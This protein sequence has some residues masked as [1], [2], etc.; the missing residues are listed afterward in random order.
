MKLKIN[1]YRKMLLYF[2][3]TTL[4][5][6]IASLGYISYKIKQISSKTSRNLL[7]TH[8]EKVG[9][10]VRGVL[11][12]NIYAVNALANAYQKYA[13]FDEK[14]RRDRLANLLKSELESDQKLLSVWTVWE[15]YA[16]DN[17]DDQCILKPLV[18]P[19]GILPPLFTGTR[20]ALKWK[21]IPV[22]LLI[23][24]SFMCFQNKV[25]KRSFLNHTTIA[26]DKQIPIHL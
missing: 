3:G 16:V 23:K 10:S 6:Y 22:N 7:Q 8:S 12:K 26:T 24:K 9:V 20:A 2:L 5:V 25:A 18:R 13:S 14:I 19:S 4:L 17:L 11:E 21:S 1:I 15:P